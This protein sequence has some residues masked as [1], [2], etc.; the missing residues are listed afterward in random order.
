MSTYNENTSSNFLRTQSYIAN[1]M[2]NPSFKTSKKDYLSNL[3]KNKNNKKAQNKSR[4]RTNKSNNYI[5][6]V[7]KQKKNCF[8]KP[9]QQKLLKK[10]IKNKIEEKTEIIN[11]YK[12]NDIYSRNTYI[13]NTKTQKFKNINENYLYSKGHHSNVKGNKKKESKGKENDKNYQNIRNKRNINNKS[14]GQKNEINKSNGL[15]KSNTFTNKINNEFFSKTSK[16]KNNYKFDFDNIINQTKLGIMTTRANINHKRNEEFRKDIDNIYIM[17]YR[18]KVKTNPKLLTSGK[19]KNFINKILSN[20]NEDYLDI[21]NHRNKNILLDKLN[22]YIKREKVSFEEKNKTQRGLLTMKNLINRNKMFFSPKTTTNKV[23]NIPK[24]LFHISY[25][26]YRQ[27]HGILNKYSKKVNSRNNGISP[28]LTEYN[29]K[30]SKKNDIST[31]LFKIKISKSLSNIINSMT[32]QRKTTKFIKDLNKNKQFRN[33]SDKYIRFTFSPNKGDDSIDEFY[34]PNKRKINHIQKIN[35][36]K[37]INYFI[38]K[39]ISS[40]NFMRKEKKKNNKN[41]INNK[42]INFINAYNEKKHFIM[43]VNDAIN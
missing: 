26:N 33:N 2:P 35:N 15:H 39:N 23:Y 29:N 12:N 4:S 31:D 16:V 6:D 43:P 11:N 40:D 10:F 34:S 17:T 30:R 8:K 25:S 3:I 37:K 42:L 20:D 22:Y 27:Y 36:K 9:S 19:V 41:I 18:S 7:K 13:Y 5:N 38:K 14:N 21:K 24:N 32:E 1:G 28:V